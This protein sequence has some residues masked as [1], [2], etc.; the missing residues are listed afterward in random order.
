MV[1]NDVYLRPVGLEGM[2]S[3]ALILPLPFQPSR[4]RRVPTP[5]KRWRFRQTI[6]FYSLLQQSAIFPSVIMHCFQTEKC[7]VLSHLL[8]R[9]SRHYYLDQ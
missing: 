6:R 2:P 8:T 4:S 7:Q 3:A 5:Y 1:T 9:Q